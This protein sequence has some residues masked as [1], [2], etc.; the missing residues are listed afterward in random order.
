MDQTAILFV[1]GELKFPELVRPILDQPVFLIAVDGGL[2]HLNSLKLFPDLLIGDLDSV[3]SKD[4]ILIEK[5]KIEIKKY[6]VQKDESDL[7]LAIRYSVSMGF[8]KIVIVGALGGRVDQTLANISLL[9]NPEWRERDLILFDGV[10]E[11]RLIHDEL[12]IAGN[13]GNAI[14]LIPMTEKVTGVRTEGLVY[15][16]ENEDLFQW[17]TRGISNV[18]TGKSASISIQGG[19]V[20]CIHKLSDLKIV[21]I[22]GENKK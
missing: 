13:Q 21:G 20:I 19:L 9:T 15:P 22:N 6:P 17:K 2:K 12:V 3:D 18:M 11:I 14:S 7:E 10:I 5:R 1:N 4:L 16:L 8:S